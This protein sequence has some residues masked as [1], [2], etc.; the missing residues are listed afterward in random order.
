MDALFITGVKTYSGI[1]HQI[2]DVSLLLHF[3]IVQV[4]AQVWGLLKGHQNCFIGLKVTTVLMNWWILYIGEI[5]LGS[6]IGE[7]LRLQPAQQA[8]SP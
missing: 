4:S 7:V 6:F 3:A 8:C 5:C 1:V 2:F